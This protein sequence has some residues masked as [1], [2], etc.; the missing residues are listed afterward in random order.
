MVKRFS[1]EDLDSMIDK[2]LNPAPRNVNVGNVMQQI[3][4]KYPF[5]SKKRLSS[6][7]GS[8]RFPET[9]E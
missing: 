4:R 8:D 7:L 5:I 3:R 2:E 9:E 1:I 6:P